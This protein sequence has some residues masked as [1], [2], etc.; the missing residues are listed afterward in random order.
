MLP[1]A[2]KSICYLDMKFQIHVL[3]ECASIIDTLLDTEYCMS[4]G[5][6]CDNFVDHFTNAVGEV[7][8]DGG[9]IMS[10][11]LLHTFCSIFDAHA[12]MIPLE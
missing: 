10:Q 2:A 1:L 12:G 7:R 5:N 8:W 9:L 4:C 6:F 3:V 11:R